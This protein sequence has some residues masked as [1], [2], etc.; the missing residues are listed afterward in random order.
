MFQTWLTWAG[1]AFAVGILAACS[2]AAGTTG[3]NTPTSGPNYK[4]RDIL[5]L[6]VAACPPGTTSG[7]SMVSTHTFDVTGPDG[8]ECV[9]DMINQPGNGYSRWAC[10]VPTSLGTIVVQEF[11]KL[12]TDI[13]GYRYGHR[14]SFDLGNFCTLA[15]CGDG[16][17][18]PADCPRGP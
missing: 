4:L 6:D 14:Y 1:L 9:F 11:D 3:Y 17:V 8:D 12:V 2:Y 15:A 10:R 16:V 5:T 13:R 7:T 18:F